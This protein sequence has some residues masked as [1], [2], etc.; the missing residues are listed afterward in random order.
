MGPRQSVAPFSFVMQT[1]SLARHAMATRFEI[2]LHGGNESSLRAAA[3]EALQEVTQIE[4][5]LSL[6]QPHS[7]ITAINRASAT[8]PVRV[9]GDVFGLLKRARE[10]SELTGGLFDITI[11]PLLRCWGFMGGTG[12]LPS[13]DAIEQAREI[14]GWQNLL[15][16]E[17]DLSV[18]FA[19]PGMMLDLGAIGKGYAVDVAISILQEAG[20][21]HA[22]LHGGTSTIFGLGVSPEG[23]PWRVSL[24]YP[25]SKEPK[26]R[27]VIEL[28][29]E[30]VSVSG[31]W[32][33][34]FEAEGKVL[35]HVIDPQTGWPVDGAK[36]TAVTLPS[37]TET[38]AISTAFLVGGSGRFAQLR[39]IRE[40]MR[41]LVIL[42]KEGNLEVLES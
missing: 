28:Q 18:R 31:V 23:H 29:N 37:A 34:A 4:S 13:L 32:G 25:V 1:I 8:M 33:K 42:E 10:L 39:S 19:K 41:S 3:E 15:L 36:M 16:N 5:K 38:D 11:G 2:V 12:S 7:Q 35:G 30:A 21:Y 20:V 26:F 27:K 6:Y 24:E 9:S 40:Q 14:S 22:L 17:N